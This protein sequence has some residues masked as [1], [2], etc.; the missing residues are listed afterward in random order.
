MI[1]EELG[2]DQSASAIE[3]DLGGLRAHQL[4]L[5]N[6]WPSPLSEALL[7]LSPAGFDASSLVCF[8]VIANC[9]REWMTALVLSEF[10]SRLRPKG[11]ESSRDF[12]ILVART[13]RALRTRRSYDGCQNVCGGPAQP[14]R[15]QPIT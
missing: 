3:R 15:C 7:C 9:R 14:I 4:I 6:S 10:P 8:A 12:L 1:G 5:P 2:N 11:G 13:P